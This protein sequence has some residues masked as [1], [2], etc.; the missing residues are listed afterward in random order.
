M[1]GP[2][3]GEWAWHLWVGVACVAG[4]GT[5]PGMVVGLQQDVAPRAQ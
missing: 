2:G 5:E 3:P 1:A 4:T